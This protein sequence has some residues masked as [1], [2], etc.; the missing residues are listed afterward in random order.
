M[1]DV[2]LPETYFGAVG[3]A[4]D[5]RDAPDPGADDDALLA[6]TPADVVALLGFDPLE[7]EIRADAERRVKTIDDGKVAGQYDPD[8]KSIRLADA[9][10]L[11]DGPRV[12]ANPAR[13]AAHEEGHAKDHALDWASDVPE[14]RALLEPAADR[15]T[16]EERVGARYYLTDPGEAFAEAWALL[17]GPEPGARYFGT[18]EPERAREVLGEIVE[19]VRNRTS[20]A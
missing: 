15:L 1:A 19:W 7:E 2:E 16:P 20:L 9:I 8:T 13:V 14:F 12:I 6:R 11:G 4:P 5:W 17:Q 18:M 3:S 10:Q